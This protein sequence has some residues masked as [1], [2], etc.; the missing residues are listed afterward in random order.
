MSYRTFTGSQIHRLIFLLVSALISNQSLTASST[1]LARP[2][3]LETWATR[4]SGSGGMISTRHKRSRSSR[5]QLRRVPRLTCQ[6]NL[7]DQSQNLSPRL[8]HDSV[9]QLYSESSA[10]SL[11]QSLASP[12]Q[13]MTR[14]RIVSL[15]PL[16]WTSAVSLVIRFE[17][18]MGAVKK[19]MSLVCSENLSCASHIRAYGRTCGR[20]VR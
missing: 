15:A 1:S 5:R 9:C 2:T 4:L 13:N 11:V 10:L 6:S 12:S 14:P 16:Q 20:L 19:Q 17:S 18:L 7:V 3:V 8:L